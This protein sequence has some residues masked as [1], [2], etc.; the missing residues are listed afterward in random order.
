[1]KKLCFIL[2]FCMMSVLGEH[3]VAQNVFFN[4]SATA[5]TISVGQP[6]DYQL[7]LTI[8]KDY[9]VEW[10]Q[11]DDT[12]SKSIDVIEAGDVITTPIS[13]SDNVRMTQNLKLTSFDTG[14]VYVPSIEIVYSTSIK[15]SI[16]KTLR[17]AD[18]EIYVTTV[19]VDT[20]EAFRPIKDVIRQGI[21]AKEA[22][23]W[24][25]LVIVLAGIVY[26]I[27]YLSKHKKEKDVVVVEKKKPTIPAIVTARAKLSE[28]REKELWNS[29]KTKDYYTDLTDIAREYLEGQF[30][31]DAVEMTTDEILQAVHALSISEITKSKL[32]DTLITADLVK[33]AKANPSADENEQ[34]FK[35]IDY[36]VED[37][38][39][40]CQSVENNKKEEETK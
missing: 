35:D 1:M 24:I 27:I 32:Q 25:G 34:S 33:F 17:T 37:S 18:Y 38:Y 8:P 26:L 16:R 6:F 19:A 21:T 14:Y 28:M 15:D 5:D 4:R 39:A 12:L 7:L 29:L 40:Y 36:F 13:N 10:K 22:L 31:I 2:L 11:F 20:T 23:F 30:K 9:Y 3:C